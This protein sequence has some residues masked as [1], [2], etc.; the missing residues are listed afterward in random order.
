MIKYHK[1]TIAGGL[2]LIGLVAFT[3]TRNSP[4]AS[5]NSNLKTPKNN[6]LETA[7]KPKRA[8]KPELT[9]EPIKVLARS[10]VVID[11]NSGELLIA[12]DE[13]KQVPIASTTKVMTAIVLLRSSKNLD[14]TITISKEAASQIGSGI[15]LKEGEKIKVR[16]LLAGLLI[17]SGNDA[18]YAIAE[19]FGG[20]D[21]FVRKM[22]ATAKELGLKQ[23]KFFDPAGLNDEGK[24][25]AFDLAMIFR[26]ALTF[27]EF[28]ELI[29]TSEMT[30][31]TSNGKRDFK[32][33][34]RLIKQN[35]SLFLADS[36]GGKTGFTPDAGH[37]LVTAAKRNDHLLIAVVLHTI[38]ELPESSAKE[39]RR[40][41]TWAF[42]NV[43][44]K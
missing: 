2:L 5:S 20:I 38:E 8:L 36:I 24:S 19:I 23:T 14:E 26:Y 42:D 22:N 29:E 7:I 35:E 25:S 37:S 3:L 34:N 16:E 17:V 9:N 18:A 28:R 4:E 15:G 30:I 43:V 40:L 41:L 44:W 13:H 32:N 21:P 33:S 11:S 39:A 31:E 27:D 1:N 6:Q 10:A 12:K